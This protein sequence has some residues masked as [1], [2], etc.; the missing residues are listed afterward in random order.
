MIVDQSKYGKSDTIEV[1]LSFDDEELHRQPEH[2][3]S[4]MITDTGHYPVFS[5]DNLQ[6][7]LRSSRLP[8]LLR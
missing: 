7:G 5:R 6:E 1:S 8:V 3:T 4:G 2:D